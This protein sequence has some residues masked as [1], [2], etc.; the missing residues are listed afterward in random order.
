MQGSKREA[1]ITNDNTFWVFISDSTEARHTFDVIHAVGVLLSKGVS[2]KAIRYFTDDAQA[3][4]FTSAFNYPAPMPIANL[5]NEIAAAKGFENLFLVVTGHG[6]AEGIGYPVKI[7]PSHLVSVAR[8]APNAE[9]VVIAL[10]QCFA[11]VFNFADARS[12]PPIVMLGAANLGSSLSTPINFTLTAPNGDQLS[13]WAANSF[14]FY[15]FRWFFAPRDID[16]DGQITL[17]DAY[18]YSGSFASGEIIQTKPTVFVESQQLAAKYQEIKT[19]IDAENEEAIKMKRPPNHNPQD[20]LNFQAAKTQLDEKISI[21]HISQEPWLLH[22][23]L[24]R[25][26]KVF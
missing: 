14:M 8:S 18:K 12:K 1:S 7:S 17:L 25:N 26:V 6:W 21:L 20:L 23:D 16:G 22:A 13:G 24:A 10:T 19:R 3:V 15:L 2:E 5:G 4:K 11:G 9:L